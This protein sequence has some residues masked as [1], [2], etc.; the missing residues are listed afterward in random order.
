MSWPCC[1]DRGFFVFLTYERIYESYLNRKTLEI[2]H[3]IVRSQTFFCS[4]RLFFISIADAPTMNYSCRFPSNQS[5][6]CKRNT[7]AIFSG[8]FADE[9][10][11][12][13]TPLARSNGCVKI[14][15]FEVERDIGDCG[16]T[17]YVGLSGIVRNRI[18]K[19]KDMA[20][21]F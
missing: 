19:S 5:C 17:L 4:S 3:F 2:V 10:T 15:A 20:T 21:L 1:P 16:S 18:Q 11:S 6:S 14:H 8:V 7:T 9:N 13:A 12:G